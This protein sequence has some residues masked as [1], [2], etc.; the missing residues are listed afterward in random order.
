L[1]I[2]NGEITVTA[3]DG[4]RMAVYKNTVIS[5]SGFM[6]IVCPARTMSEVSKM[7]S[8]DGEL[9]VYVQ[10]GMMM[11]KIENTTVMSRLYQGEFIN[12]KSITPTEFL[13]NVTV[14]K[15]ELCE[16]VDRASIMIRG[17]KNNLIILEIR[18]D[19]IRITSNSEVGNVVEKVKSTLAGPE[20]RIAMNSKYILD[21][22]KALSAEKINIGFNT[23][24]SPFVLDTGAENDGFYLILPVR[25]A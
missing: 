10:N 16:S 23:P 21:A 13:T 9:T 8:E 18:N 4:F 3:L 11:V 17:D 25:T 19:G 24:T 5:G 2:N 1:D 22:V 7:L 12:Y 14:D 6:H 15:N 20:L